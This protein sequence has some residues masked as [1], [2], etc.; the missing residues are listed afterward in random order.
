MTTHTA[1]H[2][3]FA[4]PAAARRAGPWLGLAHALFVTLGLG[5]F[6]GLAW[7]FGPEKIFAHVRSLGWSLAIALLPYLLVLVLDAAAWRYA[8]GRAVPLGLTRL[9][10]IHV[11][12]KAVNLVTP[13][14]PIGGEPL[15]AYLAHSRG[16]PLAEGFASVVISRT[17]ATIAHGIFVVASTVIALLMLD[18]PTA[19]LQAVLGTVAVGGLLVGTF[20]MVQT[21]GLFTGLL[22]LSRRAGIRLAFPDKGAR[23]LDDRI[24]RYYRHRSGRLLIALALHLLSWLAEGLEAYVLLALL[25]LPQSLGF[26]VVLAALASVVRAA[27]FAIPAS[28]G[29]QEGGNAAIF[30]SF[31]LPAPAAIAFTILTRLRQLAWSGIGFLLLSWF[32][33]PGPLAAGGQRSP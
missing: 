10:A 20:L 7:Q 33:G 22:R 9:T 19:L 14:V 6:V 15:K 5:V 1:A 30:L 17:L 21:R 4:A 13:L 11:M 27:S 31:G 32:G 29:I 26:A 2:S 25:G 12:A 23:D 8:F 18:V 16:V 28:L 3:S 24:S